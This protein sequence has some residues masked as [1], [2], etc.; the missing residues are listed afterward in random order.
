MRFC[1]LGKPVPPTFPVFGEGAP[2]HGT[3]HTRE[4][5]ARTRVDSRSEGIASWPGSAAGLWEGTQLSR[6]QRAKGEATTLL[7]T[8]GLLVASGIAAW[9][10]L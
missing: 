6:F 5:T 7:L 8:D 4:R 10:P 3:V 1:S 9:W 2:A